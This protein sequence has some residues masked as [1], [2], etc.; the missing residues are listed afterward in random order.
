[1]MST[2]NNNIMPDFIAYLQGEGEGCDYTIGCNQELIILKAIKWK[3]AFEE[4]KKIVIGS[5]D[6]S[7]EDGYNEPK[8]KEARLFKVQHEYSVPVE[9]WYKEA[10]GKIKNEEKIV[11]DTIEKEEYE[12][13][14]SKFGEEV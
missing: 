6:D 3:D 8:I 10:E 1:M 12:R 14:K 9:E 11:K 5:K 2:K 4:L 13:L 7:Y